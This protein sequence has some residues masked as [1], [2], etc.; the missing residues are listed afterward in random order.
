MTT[1]LWPF[2]Y[3]VAEHMQISAPRA[4]GLWKYADMKVLSTTKMMSPRLWT[5]CAQASMSVSFKVGFV[6]VSI[7]TSLVCGVIAASNSLILEQ[8]TKEIFSPNSEATLLKYLLV[9]DTHKWQEAEPLFKIPFLF[10]HGTASWHSI[11]CMHTYVC[12]RWRGWV[13]TVPADT[14]IAQSLHVRLRCH[15][16][17]QGGKIEVCCEIAFPRNV[18]RLSREVSS[19]WLPN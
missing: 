8:S 17:S 1:S 4:K 5:I 6:G 12:W 11:F 10:H 9:L 13:P 3:F 19:T 2:M 14:S 18:H 16:R 15:Y 7:Q